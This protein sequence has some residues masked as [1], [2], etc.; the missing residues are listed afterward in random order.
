LVQ[1][2]KKTWDTIQ[3]VV[4]RYTI[5]H[6]VTR[7]TIQQVFWY[8]ILSSSVTR[9]ILSSFVTIHQTTTDQDN[10]LPP[11][12]KTKRAKDTSDDQDNTRYTNTTTIRHVNKQDS[13]HEWRNYGGTQADTTLTRQWSRVLSALV[14]KLHNQTCK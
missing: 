6:I 12:I 13:D 1:L 5:Q 4:T 3:Q 2:I 11:A 14:P 9:N 8:N 7:Y 10:T